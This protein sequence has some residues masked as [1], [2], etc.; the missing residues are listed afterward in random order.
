MAAD[1]VADEVRRGSRSGDCQRGRDREPDVAVV[2]TRRNMDPIEDDRALDR[3]YEWDIEIV[4][5]L[6]L[7]DEKG[8]RRPAQFRSGVRA[9]QR[10]GR[11]WTQPN[12]INIETVSPS[13]LDCFCF[14]CNRHQSCLENKI[15]IC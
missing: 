1:S 9:P 3:S 12:M 11:R 4:P 10:I 8:E 14:A 2:A 13:H 5:T 6:I 15:V 7:F